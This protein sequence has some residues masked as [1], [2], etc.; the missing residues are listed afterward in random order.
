MR[1]TFD[2]EANMSYI[3][4]SEGGNAVR[5]LPVRE[6][7]RDSARFVLDLDGEGRLLG[8][9]VFDARSSLRPQVIAEAESL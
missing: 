1:V 4:L 8:I 5:Q 6:A 9:E 7:E 3:S 2:P